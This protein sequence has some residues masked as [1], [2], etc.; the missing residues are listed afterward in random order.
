MQSESLW[1]VCEAGEA[2]G[3]TERGWKVYQHQAGE[4]KGP[5]CNIQGFTVCDG[6]TTGGFWVRGAELLS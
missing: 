1:H 4:G 2:E 3:N 5:E 6:R